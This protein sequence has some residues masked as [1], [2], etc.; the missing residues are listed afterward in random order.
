MPCPHLST[1]HRNT[2]EQQ[3]GL[4]RNIEVTPKPDAIWQ[5]RKLLNYA[6][7]H[8]WFC[9]FVSF[10]WRELLW[11]ILPPG[12]RQSVFHGANIL[13]TTYTKTLWSFSTDWS[14][15]RR[16]PE[17]EPRE[18]EVKA[19]GS[20]PHQAALHQGKRKQHS[21]RPILIKYAPTPTELIPEAAPFMLIFTTS[22]RNVLVNVTEM[23][24]FLC[25]RTHN[26]SSR[27]ATA[28][29]C[30]SPKF[31]QRAVAVALCLQSCLFRLL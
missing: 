15:R 28:A 14:R 12:K 20:A 19:E 16:G 10:R 17:K 11:K 24:R 26:F 23:A 18:E 6:N 27:A 7:N 9:S 31:W 2:G 3:S 4:K 1:R 25:D 5:K 21:Q 13:I 29:D 30:G 22:V 8:C